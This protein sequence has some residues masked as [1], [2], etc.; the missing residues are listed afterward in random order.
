MCVVNP[1]NPTGDYKP[2]DDMMAWIESHCLADDMAQFG[3]N[4]H[5]D[6][7]QFG[8]GAHAHA[9]T[10]VHVLVDESMLMWLGP[11]WQDDSLASQ[12]GWLARMAARGVLVFVLH[13]WTK[14]WACPGLRLGSCACPTL[15]AADR[16]RSRQVPWSVSS[17]ALAF[18]S[19]AIQDEVRAPSPGHG[20]VNPSHPI[21]SISPA[22][23]A[24][25]HKTW[26]LTPLWNRAARELLQRAFPHWRVHGPAWTSWLWV[27]TGDEAALQ[28]ALARARDAGLPIRSGASGYDSPTC[29]RMAVRSPEL[30]RAL[31]GALLGCGANSKL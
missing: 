10:R 16:V 15:E 23:Q 21:P 5:D 7:A 2:R 13:S 18:L 14:I 17:P 22:L 3:A 4:A 27:D 12:H 20:P 6:T 24:Y 29:F 26:Q 25:L 31:V 8:A 1:C 28:T 30:T 9:P 11:R 19:A